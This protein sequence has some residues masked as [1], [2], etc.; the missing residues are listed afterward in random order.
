MRRGVE[1]LREQKVLFFDGLLKIALA[2]AEARAG[3][4]DRALAV[5]GARD[6]FPSGASRG[7]PPEG[8]R[9]S[10]MRRFVLERLR[11]R[12]IYS[13]TLEKIEPARNKTDRVAI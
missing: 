12:P 9:V 13:P 6:V 7:L 11:C 8:T 2:E 1:S 5:L 3:D 4:P 10:H